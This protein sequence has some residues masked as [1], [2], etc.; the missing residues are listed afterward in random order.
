[1]LI[2]G[3]RRNVSQP[4]KVPL[5]VRDDI[6]QFLYYEADLL[7]DRQ[8]RE[9]LDLLAD[10]ITYEVRTRPNLDP[11]GNDDAIPPSIAF[12][13]NKESLTWRVK[14]AE[15]GMAWAEEPPSRTRY[16]IS[17][18]RVRQQDQALAVRSNFLL[19][20]NRLETT[21]HFL[22]GTRRDSLLPVRTEEGFL[23]TRRVVTLDQNVI[24]ANNL[25]MFF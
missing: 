14:R 25:S 23:I 15:S 22:V 16:L 24:L 5:E 10:E 4:D 19:Y 1:V 17:N 3:E 12:E 6:E 11:M 21:V 2:E 7:D 20:R 8:Y 18:I 13:D 9:W